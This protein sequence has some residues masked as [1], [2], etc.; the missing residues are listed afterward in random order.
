MIRVNK[1]IKYM[2]KLGPCKENNKI[3]CVCKQDKCLEKEE[4]KCE[5]VATSKPTD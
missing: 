2:G 3:L 5:S 4:K 1:I